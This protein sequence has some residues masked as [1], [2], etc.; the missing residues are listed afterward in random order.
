MESHS[1][2]VIS[3]PFSN[4]ALC[5]IIFSIRN[6]VFVVEQ[7]VSREE[8]FD[9]FEETSVHYLGT[10]DNVP[11]GT[12]RWRITKNGIK[13]ERFAVLSSM[14]NTGI[15]STILKRVLADVRTTGLPVYL[16]AQIKAIPFYE[17]QGFKKVGELF[18]EAN[19]DHFKM[20]LNN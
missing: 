13:L 11:A 14:R 7:K 15:G 8:E 6:Q 18:V 1:I 5:E 4:K 3:C 9:E 12:A 20:V 19:I 10:V 2:A 17:R 16:N